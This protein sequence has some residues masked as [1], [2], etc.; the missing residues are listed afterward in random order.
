MPIFVFKKKVI[1]LFKDVA[2]KK[3]VALEKL[4]KLGDVL[5]KIK[6]LQPDPFRNEPQLNRS[7]TIQTFLDWC[8]TVDITIEGITLKEHPL[9]YGLGV[10]A[11][12]KLLPNDIVVIVPYN[13]TIRWSILIGE[14]KNFIPTDLD[15]WQVK[16]S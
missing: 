10:Y 5:R 9:G 3:S 16:Q 1:K 13:A 14:F 11:T 7:E 2:N 6:S 4:K 8:E 12:K 15:E